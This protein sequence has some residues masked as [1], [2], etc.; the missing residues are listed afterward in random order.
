LVHVS[1]MAP[2]RVEK[3]SDIV[4][5]GDIVHVKVA[6][7]DNLGRINLSMKQAPGNVYPE[8]PANAAPSGSGTG[9]PFPP[10]SGG[11]R[12]PMRGGRP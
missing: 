5:V 6:E 9:R 4:K 11:G 12:P 2:W 1:E 10:R 7:I 3:V 8:K